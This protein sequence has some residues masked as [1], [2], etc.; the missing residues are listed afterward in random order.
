LREARA[1]LDDLGADVL[2]VGRGT[3]HQ[4]RH[5]SRTTDPG[6]DLLLDPDAHVTDALEMR[7]FAGWKWLLPTTWWSY[8]RWFGKARQGRPAPGTI[9]GQPGVVIVDA[10]AR[11][12]W[13]HRGAVVGDYPPMHEVLGALRSASR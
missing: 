13:A 5:I 1:E 10:D 8:G 3:D 12:V 6:F 2:A 11:V 7:G 9:T 4:V